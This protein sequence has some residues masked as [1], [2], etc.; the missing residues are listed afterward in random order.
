MNEA[1]TIDR[2]TTRG[3]VLRLLAGCT[4]LLLLLAGCG[5]EAEARP[6]GE[7]GAFER[8]VNVEVMPLEPSS[9]VELIRLTGTIRAYQDVTVAAEE[10]G[11][12]RELLVEEGTVVEEGQPIARVDDRILRAQTQEARAQ[13]ELARESWERRQRLYEDDGVGSELDYLQARYEA[14]RSQAN[15]EALEQRLD[16]TLIRAPI[17]GTLDRTE[18]EVGSMVSSGSPVGRIV[19]TNPVKVRGGVPERYADDVR[20]GSRARV[21]F[22]VLDAEVTEVEVSYV[23]STVDPQNRTFDAEV[24]IPNPGRIIKPEMV[25]NVEIVRQVH[26]DVLVVPQEALVREEGGYVAYVVEE[27]EEGREV[28]RERLLE[29]GP[30]QRNLV[31]V[32]EGLSPGEELVVVGQN[33]VADL[34][35]VRVVERQAPVRDPRSDP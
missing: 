8:T 15:L 3:L 4:L 33:R 13:S 6:D 2:Y 22:D 21:T 16:R 19:R 5:G 12:I 32:W 11:V 27:D 25:A 7:E 14:D 10:G 20:R 23:G 34:E 17:S 30:A 31:V 29:L 18:V 35:R 26:E 28:V 9:F 24:I 1:I